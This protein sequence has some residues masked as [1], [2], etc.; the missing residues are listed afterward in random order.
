[1]WGLVKNQGACLAIEGFEARL[2]GLILGR[3]KTLEDKTVTGSP[4]TDN[5]AM[6][7]LGPGMGTTSSPSRR[8]RLTSS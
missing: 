1:M 4:E 5:A 3:Q 7:A 2:S 6:T 8:A